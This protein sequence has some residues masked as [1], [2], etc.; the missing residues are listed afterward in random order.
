MRGRGQGKTVARIRMRP[1]TR[2]RSNHQASLLMSRATIGASHLKPLGMR[3]A[4]KHAIAGRFNAGQLC[5]GGIIDKHQTPVF[6]TANGGV[7]F[8]VFDGASTVAP[9]RGVFAG[10]QDMAG[11]VVHATTPPAIADGD[12]PGE[13]TLRAIQARQ[14]RLWARAAEN[15]CRD[16]SRRIMAKRPPQRGST[17][18]AL[19][20]TEITC[21][22]LAQKWR[23]CL[24]LIQ[25]TN[26]ARLW[27]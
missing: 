13:A 14:L 12:A 10:A 3:E 19:A 6:A 24:F 27:A 20:S 17:V 22:D 1:S 23:G 5:A 21:G 16:F 25:V 11:F 2:R 8:A 7:G 4:T 15:L 18:A 9:H 26:L